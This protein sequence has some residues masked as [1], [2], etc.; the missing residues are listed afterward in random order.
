MEAVGNAMNSR[1]RGKQLAVQITGWVGAASVA[2]AAVVGIAVSPAAVSGTAPSNDSGRITV[3]PQTG[4]G[5]RHQNGGYSPVRP[6]DP[7]SGAA[8]GRSSGS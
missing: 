7:G 3:P 8:L 5:S 6:A 4:F 1:D 2:G